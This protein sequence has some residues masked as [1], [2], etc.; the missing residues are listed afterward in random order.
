MYDESAMT[1]APCA[2]F[3]YGTLLEGERDHAL[4]GAAPRLGT[5]CTEPA[6]ELVDLGAFAAMVPGG[7][8]SVAGELYAIDLKTLAGIDVKRQV[9]ILFRRVAIRLVDGGQAQ[10]YVMTA[11]QVRGRRRLHDGNWRTRFTS[12]VPRPIESPIARWARNRFR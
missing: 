6:F 12:S 11:D 2:L 9:P 4:L 10:A 1:A 5:A 7:T 3:V 8:V